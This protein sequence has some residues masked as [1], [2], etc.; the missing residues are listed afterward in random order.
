MVECG[1]FTRQG[2]HVGSGIQRR[3]LQR[4]WRGLGLMWDRTKLSFD[5]GGNGGAGRTRRDER[6]R[7]GLQTT[8]APTQLISCINN[9]I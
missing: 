5:L 3:A 1:P 4:L 6:M 7:Q 2:P 8:T 9:N